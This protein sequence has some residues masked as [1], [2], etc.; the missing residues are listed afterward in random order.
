MN[1]IRRRTQLANVRGLIMAPDIAEA[2][3]KLEK[4]AAET[5]KWRLVLSG[6]K[7]GTDEGNPLSM[8]PAG[9]EIRMSFS[10]AD[11]K[12]P[13]AALCAL[14]GFAVPLGF[15][16]WLRWPVSGIGDD[17]F[18]FL[19]PWKMVGDRLLA[20]GRGHL[21]WPSMCAAAQADAGVWKG[22]DAERRFVQAQLHR[23]GKNCGPVDGIVASRTL[24][25]IEAAGLG[26]DNFQ[27]IAE[28]LRT[29]EP[30]APSPA[31]RN[32]GHVSLPGRKLVL[33]AFG[34]V[35]CVQNN[36]GAALTVDGP[37][38]LVVDVG[39]ESR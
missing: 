24:E 27:K 8:A 39:E 16:P 1:A 7:S 33:S 32:V 20:E 12:D 13:Q 35:K 25:A 29:A 22:D 17:R 19:G 23:I 21:A 28:A 11:V 15:T 3:A 18:F 4:T 36:Q 37:G 31:T 5:A 10:R 34:G 30:P 26:G 6:P 14:W 9:R 38:R 2:V